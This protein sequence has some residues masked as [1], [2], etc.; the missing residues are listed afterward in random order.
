MTALHPEFGRLPKRI[1][2]RLNVRNGGLMHKS[3]LT[4]SHPIAVE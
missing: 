1:E 2:M 3:G 4:A